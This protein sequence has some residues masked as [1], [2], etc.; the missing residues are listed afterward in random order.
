M[1]YMHRI[2]G[3]DRRY[4][5]SMDDQIE[6]FLGTVVARGLH[7]P[8]SQADVESSSGPSRPADATVLLGAG[9]ENRTRTVSLGS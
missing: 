7:G 2:H 9:D 4:K 1:I 5:T 8:G 3:T 6:A